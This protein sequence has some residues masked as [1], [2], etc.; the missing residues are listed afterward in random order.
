MVFDLRQLTARHVGRHRPAAPLPAPFRTRSPPGGGTCGA[1]SD[2]RA[3]GA[4][5]PSR[6]RSF[7][8]FGVSVGD[9]PGGHRDVA[10]APGPWTLT[11]SGTAFTPASI[12][13]WTVRRGG[14]GPLT[15]SPGADA[16]D[17]RAAQV[18]GALLDSTRAQ[19]PRLHRAPR[20]VERRASRGTPGGDTNRT[21]GTERDS[22]CH[23]GGAQPTRRASV[24]GAPPC[25]QSTR[26]PSR[27]PGVRG[28]RTG[29]APRAGSVARP[30]AGP[31]ITREIQR[32]A[33]ITAS[34]LRGVRPP[35]S[36]ARR[37]HSGADRRT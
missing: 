18:P 34:R 17:D 1:P 16:E 24:V 26:R 10:P 9:P 33:G 27:T 8:R 32:I 25:S 22:S 4:A 6:T 14:T 28:R 30:R 12:T 23:R 19:T 3:V 11:G 36:R 20:G 5:P 31:A 35:G 13:G 21:P 15:A 37:G 7:S 29:A 2:V